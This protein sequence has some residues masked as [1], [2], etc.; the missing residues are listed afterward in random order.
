MFSA[1]LLAKFQN[2]L[3]LLWQAHSQAEAI[4]IWTRRAEW[5]GSHKWFGRRQAELEKV[6]REVQEFLNEYPKAD[7]VVPATLAVPV[8]FSDLRA[9]YQVFLDAVTVIQAG[10]IDTQTAAEEAGQSD[11]E[12][13]CDDYVTDN[14]DRVMSLNRDLALLDRAGN[15]Q[16]AILIFDRDQR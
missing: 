6:F 9:C 3:A 8:S 2:Q 11:A 4:R 10:W 16:A 12:D 15:D 5:R 1:E 7:T 14:V 13:F